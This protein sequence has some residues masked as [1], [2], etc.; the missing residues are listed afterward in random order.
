MLRVLHCLPAAR[1]AALCSFFCFLS[2]FAVLFVLCCHE[3]N[4]LVLFFLSAFALLSLL[5]CL[6]AIRHVDQVFSPLLC[7]NCQTVDSQFGVGGLYAIP[8]P[9]HKYYN[10]QDLL[11]ID[12]ASSSSAD[13]SSLLLITCLQHLGIAYSLPQRLKRGGRNEPWKIEMRICGSSVF[14]KCSRTFSSVPAVNTT[15]SDHISG[16]GTHHFS[17]EEPGTVSSNPNL[18]VSDAL[19]PRDDLFSQFSQSHALS[20]V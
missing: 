17:S 18:I 8:S 14:Q 11:D 9:P 15:S 4:S 5:Y 10:R 1:R 7:R 2:A 16:K 12:T 13:L 3:A 19:L 20:V 6:P